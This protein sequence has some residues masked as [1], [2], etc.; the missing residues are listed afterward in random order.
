MR[1]PA[2]L[3][4]LEDGNYRRLFSGQTL[5]YLGDQMTPVA[6]TFAVLDQHG[7]AAQVGWVLGAGTATMV[8]FLLLGGAIADRLPRRL[9]MLAAD[10]VR[11][12]AQGTVA[13]LLLT[14][15]WHLWELV[16]LEALW[17]A[18]SAFFNPALT[19]LMPQLLAGEPLVQANALMNMSRSLGSIVGPALAGLLVGTAGA[20]SAVAI[21][22]GTF[23]V[24]AMT[25]ARVRT[26]AADAPAGRAS[27]LH[28]LRQGWVEFRSRSWL[29]SIVAEFSVWHLLVFAPFIVLGAVVAKADLGGATAWGAILSAFGAGSLVGATISLHLR[30][31]RPLLVASLCEIGFIPLPGL[32]AAHAP[33][34]LIGAVAA[35]SGAGFAV[36]G[37]LW[38]TTM[39]QQVP[40][41]ILSR[42]S[43]Y[44][45]FGSIALLPVGYAIAGPLAS[46]FGLTTMLFAATVIMAVL[47]VAVLAVPSVRRLEA[48]TGRARVAPSGGVHL[49]NERA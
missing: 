45:W 2:R 44:D 24:S 48:G 33:V 19:G 6:V 16:F 43:S 34:P 42:V 10:V 5:S 11:C 37:T 28:D 40:R 4:A 29:W 3:A 22:A 12:I 46:I 20:G 36:F 23:A 9:V 21:D 15:H 38:D 32:V 30:P 17:G 47:V 26:P 14:G 27:I 1:L 35:V 18:G 31:R 49:S 8:A 25:L 41:E 39:Q 13:V 7:D